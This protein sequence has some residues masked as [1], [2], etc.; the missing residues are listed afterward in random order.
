M[1]QDGQCLMVT[2]CEMLSEANVRPVE[3][4]QFGAA[5]FIQRADS[6]IRLNVHFHCLVL[7]GV[8]VHDGEGQLHFHALPRPTPEQVAE[9]ARWTHEAIA[10]GF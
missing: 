9:A 4:A 2:L 1:P 8:Y 10:R 7:D 5:T 3:D 6:S